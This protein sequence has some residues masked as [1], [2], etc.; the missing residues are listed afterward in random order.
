MTHV[1]HV[2]TDHDWDYTAVITVTRDSHRHRHPLPDPADLPLD[3]LA[4]L[5]DWAHQGIQSRTRQENTHA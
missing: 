1:H 5:L 2:A 3:V 4:V